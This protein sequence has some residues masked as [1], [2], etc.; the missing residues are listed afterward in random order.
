MASLGLEVKQKS[1]KGQGALIAV[2]AGKKGKTGTAAASSK[3]GSEAALATVPEES[4]AEASAVSVAASQRQKSKEEGLDLKANKQLM[5]FVL[6][7]AKLSLGSARELA[8][9]KSIILEVVLFSNADCPI[10]DAMKDVTSAFAEKAKASGPTE[11]ASLGSP[12]LYVWYELMTLTKQ[13]LQ[14]KGEAVMLLSI[15]SHLEDLDKCAENLMKEQAVVVVENADSVKQQFLRQAV[16]SQVK[17]VR[18][19][20][21]WNPEISRLE[22]NVVENTSAVAA[23]AALIQMLVQFFKGQRKPDQAPRGN[24]ERQIQATIDRFTDKSKE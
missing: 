9:V 18:I 4:K 7:I 5:Q 3:S 20:R 21:C 10:K 14:D 11:K 22:I 17:V 12:H 13:I 8:M 2:A 1:K 23:K 15:A 24:L 6:Q 16:A 19:R